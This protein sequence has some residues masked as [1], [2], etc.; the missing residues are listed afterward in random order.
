M[1]ERRRV[2][3]LCRMTLLCLFIS[4]ICV[5]QVFAD[6]FR[7]TIY[8][9]GSLKPTDSA[10]LVKVGDMAPDFSLPDLRGGRI[11]LSDFRGKQNVVLSFVPAA[12]TPVCSQQWPGYNIVKDL[13]E[14]KNAALIGISVDNIPTLH[15]WTTQMGNLWFHVA[16][17]FWPHGAVAQKYGV[18]RSDGVAER[19]TIIIDKNG[20]VRFV[21]VHDINSIPRLE[22]LVRE[23]SKLTK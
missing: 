5:F 21:E 3:F 12:W 23:L 1:I 4:M 2:L 20:V 8:N 13:F 10:P 16:S 7:D 6:D 15:A 19:A 17:D 9:P 14:D 22:G 18:L 11:S